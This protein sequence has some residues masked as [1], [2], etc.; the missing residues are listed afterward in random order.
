MK[1]YI[2]GKIT[3]GKNYKRKFAKA[4]RALKKKSSFCNE[5]SVAKRI[6]RIWMD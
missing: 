4:E 6:R 5:P 3:G 1:I 2:A